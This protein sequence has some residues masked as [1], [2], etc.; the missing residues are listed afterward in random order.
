MTDLDDG[1]SYDFRH[2]ADWDVL[3]ISFEIDLFC[4]WLLFFLLLFCAVGSVLVELVCV[5]LIV[6]AFGEEEVIE[7]RLCVGKCFFV[8][9][10]LLVE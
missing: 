8:V 4:V 1:L 10:S 3:D 2:G 9:Y 5:V 7:F 6:F